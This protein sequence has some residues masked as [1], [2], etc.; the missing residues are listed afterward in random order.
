MFAVRFPQRI[1]AEYSH[2]THLELWAI[3]IAVKVW[4]NTLRGKVI[5]I[6]TDNEAVSHL[7]NSGRSQDLLLQKQ[8]RE[9]HWWLAKYEFRIKGVHIFGIH[10]RIPDLLSR[11][12]DS[13]KARREF[14]NT[15]RGMNLRFVH[16][17]QEMFDLAHEW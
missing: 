11:F 3:I 6:N 13:D 5:R 4:D 2:I 12:F 16:V 8:L 17:N 14:Y 1:K 7:L 15:T 9:L 10:N